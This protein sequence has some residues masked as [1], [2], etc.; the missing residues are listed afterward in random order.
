MF[1]V[2]RAGGPEDKGRCKLEA[3]RLRGLVEQRALTF[4]VA[5]RWPGWRVAGKR[6]RYKGDRRPDDWLGIYI[7]S[8]NPG[9]RFPFE[10]YPS[11]NLPPGAA[12]RHLRMNR[13][14]RGPV[15]TQRGGAARW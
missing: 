12:T 13:T 9:F 7:R 5:G 6:Q 8:I 2:M 14:V 15:P 3:R 11:C 1:E 10:R 4:R